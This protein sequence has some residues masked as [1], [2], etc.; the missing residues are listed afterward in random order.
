MRLVALCDYLENRHGINI[1]WN[2]DTASFDGKYLMIRIE[3][4]MTL[5]DFRLEFK[6]KDPGRLW[7]KK[8]MNY[9]MKKLTMYLDP[10]TPL[11]ELPRG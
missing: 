9:L 1:T 8:A 7:R 2:G 6:G 5:D 3:G 11:E 4:L 10:E